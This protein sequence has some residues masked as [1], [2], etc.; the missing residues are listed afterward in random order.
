MPTMVE[1]LKDLLRTTPDGRGYVNLLAAE[2]GLG[3]TRFVADLCRRVRHRLPWPDGTPTP[4]HD[5][6]EVAMWVAADRNFGELVELSEAFGFGDRGG[7]YR[8]GGGGAG[9]AYHGT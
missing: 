8:Q 1:D 9:A 5:G 7:A 3:K 6:P 4:E 2:G